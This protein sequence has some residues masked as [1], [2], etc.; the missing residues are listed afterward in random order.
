MTLLHIIILAESNTRQLLKQNTKQIP[1][2]INYICAYVVFL[3]VCKT[4]HL[5]IREND[6]N[7]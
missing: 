2:C 6:I 4:Q 5:T 1:K 7:A 3:D